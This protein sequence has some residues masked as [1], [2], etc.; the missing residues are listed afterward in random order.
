[1]VQAQGLNASFLCQHPTD[2]GTIQWII[3]GIRFRAVSN[4][5]MI[6]I[7]GR[8]NATEA[9]II[10]AL[11]QFNGTEVMCVLYI[12]EANGTVTVDRSTP[13]TLTIQ[14]TGTKLK[15]IAPLHTLTL[16]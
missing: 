11:S 15:L 12:I 13:V 8:G 9:L 16:V 6:I 1:M 4:N 2:S 10:R 7:E 5:D 14:G 3:N